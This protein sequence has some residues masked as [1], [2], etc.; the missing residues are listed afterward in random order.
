[1]V[2]KVD[3]KRDIAIGAPVAVFVALSVNSVAA[4]VE[5]LTPDIRSPVSGDLT[6]VLLMLVSPCPICGNQE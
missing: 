6:R 4:E 3:L 1:M 5:S 2:A